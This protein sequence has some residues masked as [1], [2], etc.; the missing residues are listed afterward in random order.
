MTNLKECQEIELDKVCR[1]CLG[2]KSDMR[3]LFGS[4]LDE[5]L[6]SFAS[7]T[8]A[9]NDGLPECLCV[10]CVLQV[11]RAYTFKI[12]CE[13]SDLKLREQCQLQMEKA[14]WSEDSADLKSDENDNARFEEPFKKN[15]EAAED[16]DNGRQ[17]IVS[18]SSFEKVKLKLEPGIP[19]ITS[20]QTIEVPSE[21]E[22]FLTSPDQD[23]DMAAEL[24]L[25]ESGGVVT[26]DS[27][28]PNF[29][30]NYGQYAVPYDEDQSSEMLDRTDN[31]LLI[32]T[33]SS[34]HTESYQQSVIVQHYKQPES[35]HMLEISPA[36][37]AQLMERNGTD[38]IEVEI[39]SLHDHT[40]QEQLYKGNPHIP[41]FTSKP[42][43]DSAVSKKFN[44][45]DKYL[46]KKCGETFKLKIDL[47]L[48]MYRHPDESA[49]TTCGK[50][51]P[52]R[53]LR[54]HMKTHLDV[55]PH[56]CDVCKKTFADSSNLTKHKKSHTGELRN[57][58]G[59]PYLCSVCGRSFKWS[60]SLSKHFKYHTGRKLLSCKYCPKQYIESR[61]LKIHMRMHTGEKPFV[62]AICN[63]G[64]TQECNLQKHLNVHTGQKPYICDICGKGF[65][66]KGYV[67]VHM[68]VHTGER[69][70]TCSYCGKG[71]AGSKSLKV[72]ERTHTGERPY[73]CPDCGKKFSR[74]ESLV[75]HHR[76]HTG[77]KPHVCKI[78][79]KAFTSSSHL[80]GHLRSH[81]GPKPHACSVCDKRFATASSLRMHTGKVH[82]QRELFKCDFCGKY[83]DNASLLVKHYATH[84]TLVTKI[85]TIENVPGV[86]ILT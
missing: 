62:C 14:K 72:H 74:N 68:R 66:Q 4:C 37:F 38:S 12:L 56:V 5:M 11:S 53:A 42:F 40:P 82:P 33:Q 25:D 49:C 31:E 28:F 59:K 83:F 34:S 20:Q 2:K 43:E 61:S 76:S 86:K 77:E 27:L 48:H 13:K 55:K 9:R 39:A 10:Q 21:G 81:G 47:K 54:R 51:F 67:A 65:A 79:D 15:E 22:I 23:M 18:T 57:V 78:C 69:P 71:F 1:A 60:S 63:R 8:V 19:E 36:G 70:F 26:E 3:P 30:D 17:V 32:D 41:T 24:T 29:N 75:V 45:D 7:I 85:V 84:G 58:Q 64:F 73:G 50:I 80:G 52:E 16:K 44:E 6:T 46:C 35:T